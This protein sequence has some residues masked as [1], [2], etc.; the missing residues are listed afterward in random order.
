M[1]RT[2]IL[3]GLAARGADTS[4]Q[5]LSD[6]AAELGIPVADLFVVAGHPVPSELLP[7][8]RDAEAT[9]EFAYRVSHCGHAQ[10]TA[11]E[12][13]VRS[14]PRVA[15]LEPPA[16]SAQPDSPCGGPAGSGGSTVFNGLLRNRGFGIDELP[17]LGLS[18]S[19]LR[20]M[21]SRWEPSPHRRFQLCAVAGPLGWTLPDLFAVVD[22]P[23][24]EE[25]RPVVL[26]RHVGWVL[27]AAVPLTTAQLVEA[28]EEADR[29]SAREDQGV[30]QPVSQGSVAECPDFA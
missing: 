14:L 22:E 28:A 21:S 23:Y 3:R 5:R 16:P 6:L 24:A 15:T 25:L 12:E 20:T 19:T 27:E 17:F 8:A 7:P 13:F 30:W 29:L 1:E 26:C 10:L 9:G 11:L 4:P 18:R 2:D